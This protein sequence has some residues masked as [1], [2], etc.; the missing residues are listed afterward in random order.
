M[1]SYSSDHYLAVNLTKEQVIKEVAE[2]LSREFQINETPYEI[3]IIDCNGF[4][5]Y[6]G[7]NRLSIQQNFQ[8]WTDEEYDV[9]YQEAEKEWGDGNEQIKELTKQLI[10][11]KKEAQKQRQIEEANRQLKRDKAY[12]LAQF[13][14]L[15]KELGK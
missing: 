9:V 14:Q 15:K 4:N 12:K 5:F 8:E 7:D 2:L 3:A 13:E 10:D 1:E 6:W 11:N